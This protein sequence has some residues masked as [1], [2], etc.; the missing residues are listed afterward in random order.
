MIAAVFPA[1]DVEQELRKAAARMGD[2]RVT[3]A[4]LDRERPRVLD[5][6]A[7][8]FAGH[9]SLAAM[10]H[11]RELVRP[12]PLGGRK[13]G[14]PEHVQ[15]ITVKEVQERWQRYYKPKNA[16]LV[17][18]GAVDV[19]A[20]RKAIVEH[21][22]KLAPG[23][24]APPAQ[25]PGQAKLGIIRKIAVK[26]W[27]A[28]AGSEVC[29]AYAAP[30]PS[31]ELYIPYLVLAARMQA[32]VKKLG[33]GA[34][35][36]PVNCPLFDDPAALWIRV[37]ARA[38]ET[39]EQAVK[40]LKVFVAEMVEA[41]L[42]AQDIS[43]ASALFGPFLGISE[44]PDEVLA[45]NPYFVAFCLGRRQQLGIEPEKLQAGFKSLQAQDLRR[46][47]QEIFGADRYGG[48]FISATRMK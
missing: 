28:G 27:A 24:A 2:L 17:L 26:P 21:F 33:S 30:P 15:A 47:A 34:D 6:V 16:L 40:R 5:E 9:P 25:E 1:K 31:S 20:S 37:P 23:D 46:A 8:M 7:N 41:P 10:N 44:V 42:D 12:S 11:V 3:T 18:A 36:S 13:G 32:N 48:V 4:D 22:E 14:V 35:N 29:L 43:T 19:V 45:G 38:G 39:A